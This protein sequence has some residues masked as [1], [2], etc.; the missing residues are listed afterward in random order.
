M[1]TLLF[2][3]NSVP[4][5]EADAVRALL[6]EHGIDFYET[7]AGP[8]GISVAAIWLRD[9][10]DV[11]AARR[12]LDDWQAEH[13]RRMQTEYAERRRRGEHE[14]LVARL[15]RHPLRSLLYLA[16]AAGILYFSLMPFVRFLGAA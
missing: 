10:A 5:D 4:E 14:T 16:G 3:L 12:L 15:M 13:A 6:S 1:P 7:Q 9:G 2:R 8:W 11:A